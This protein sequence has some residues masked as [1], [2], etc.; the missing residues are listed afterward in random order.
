MFPNKM[1]TPQTLIAKLKIKNLY[2]GLLRSKV[3]NIK[4]CYIGVR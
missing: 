2:D 4:S 3:D 1:K